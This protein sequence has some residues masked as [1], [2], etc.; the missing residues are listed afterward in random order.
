MTPGTSLDERD[1]SRA[2]PDLQPAGMEH[3]PSFRE[4]LLNIPTM[5]GRFRTLTAIVVAQ[6]A[7]TSLL[8]L[9]SDHSFHD[10]T[11]DIPG[12]GKTMIGM[13]HYIAIVVFF[14]IGLTLFVAG[15][16]RADSRGAA[17]LLAYFFSL[18]LLSLIVAWQP[19]NV[20][21][22]I[23]VTVI[24]IFLACA[25]AAVIIRRIV[26]AKS[27]QASPVNPWVVSLL[28]FIPCTV[29][30]LFYVISHPGFFYTMQFVIGT[31]FIALYPFAAMDWAEIA[32]GFVKG[33]ERNLHL[34][35]RIGR[36]IIFSVI[37]IVLPIGLTMYTFI[38]QAQG[39][40]YRV[41]VMCLF[42]AA[43]C[44][45][46]RI[47]RFRGDWP[48]HL[49]WAP[50]ALLVT[51]LV[52]LFN[53]GETAVELRLIAFFFAGLM[54][55]VL[56]VCGRNPQW[57]SF[58]PTALLGTLIG[59]ASIYIAL[60][61]DPDNGPWLDIVQ[62]LV[63]GAVVASLYAAIA[64]VLAVG[65]TRLRNEGIATLHYPIQTV[66]TLN[67]SLV[68]VYALAFVYKLMLENSERHVIEALVIAAALLSELF[69]SGY[70]VTNLQTDW[71]PRNSRLLMFF[72]FLT[73][74]LAYTL[75]IVALHGEAKGLPDYKLFLNPENAVL[76]GLLLIGPAMLW[77]LLILRTGR[78]LASQRASVRRMR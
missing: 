67:A 32:D 43:L 34:Q 40:G 38:Q 49:P 19:L 76:S 7:A 48:V 21:I 73:F 61:S 52:I 74:T 60:F 58:A 45:L 13:A 77:C 56:C 54:S 50:T 30:A 1:P 37:A 3:E 31:P 72:G 33:L 53:R 23:F 28:I 47:A 39:Y 14:L 10:L 15:L 16:G 25:L 44:L 55:V 75:S 41:I 42:A 24:L 8:V 65:W 46:L 12:V 29:P 70:S 6:V 62:L 5:D 57:Q 17:T 51:V 27:L 78:W 9:L 18:Y 11:V 36:L 4:R 59:F 69:F 35:K 68:A 26:L 64:A 22:T 20:S 71:F 66:L 2:D 63:L